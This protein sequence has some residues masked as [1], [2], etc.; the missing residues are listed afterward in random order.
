VNDLRH[1]A[2]LRHTVRAVGGI[3]APADISDREAISAA[4]ERVVAEAGGI[5]LL[6]CNAAVMTMQTFDDHEYGSWWRQIDVNLS[7]TFNTVGAAL[8]T[9]LE[10][11]GGRIVIIAS[12][13]GVI[14]WPNASAYSASKAGVIALCKALGRELG[15]RG[16]LVNAVAP[17][18]IDTPQLAHDAAHAGVGVKEI[19]RRYA[20]ATPLRR[21]ATP[22]EI[23]A[24]VTFLCTP[25]AGAMVG[26]IVQPNGGTTR[27]PA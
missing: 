15:P 8:P 9:M 21:T 23:A 5:D 18:V 3:S 7:G 13:W 24:T 25:G 22:E 17:G 1:D 19:R 27:G 26:Q 14:G 20:E 16:V 4:V 11:G 6:V 2:G 12:E 10:R